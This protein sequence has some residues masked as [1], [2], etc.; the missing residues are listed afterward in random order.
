MNFAV[1]ALIGAANASHISQ[2]LAQVSAP[3]IE[4]AG[5][6]EGTLSTYDFIP[7]DECDCECEKPVL[8]ELPDCECDLEALEFCDIKDQLD[9]GAGDYG[10]FGADFDG[11]LVGGFLNEQCLQS[12]TEDVIPDVYAKTDGVDS[13]YSTSE[14]ASKGETTGCKT[15]KFKIH[16]S[17]EIEE[18]RC[19]GFVESENACEASTGSKSAESLHRIG[20]NF[21]DLPECSSSAFGCDCACAP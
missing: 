7:K 19:G 14:A 11:A 12:Q 20:D 6:L 4:N 21:P 5:E 2:K 13:Y 10:D 1:L 16:G 17:I 8:K 9:A 3:A 15:Q 18:E